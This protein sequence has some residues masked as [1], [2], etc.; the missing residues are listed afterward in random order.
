V[1]ITEPSA[2]TIST[3][4]TNVL[5]NGDSDGTAAAVPAGGTAPYTYSWNTSPVQTLVTATGLPAGTYTV[6]VTDANGCTAT[7]SASI[8][9]PATIVLDFVPTDASCPDAEDGEITVNISGGTSPYIINWEN[10]DLTPTSSNLAAG[11][12]TVAVTDANGCGKLDSATVR[13][14]GSFGCLIIP[15]IITPDPADGY[16]DTWVIKN[17]DIYPNAEIKVYTRWGKLIYHTKNPLAEPWDGRYANGRLVPTDSYFYILDLHDGSK[18][19]S[20]V[21]SVIR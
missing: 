3:T 12:Y 18:Q 20:G 7:G 6:T 9:E 5:C 16:N 17:I 4:E 11:T 1:T 14:A 15:D 13:F 21:I 2:F 19:R 8:T 10:G